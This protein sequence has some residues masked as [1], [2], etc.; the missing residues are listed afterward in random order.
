MAKTSFC[1][2]KIIFLVEEVFKLRSHRLSRF[3]RPLKNPLFLS[4]RAIPQFVPQTAG[5]QSI[6]LRRD[7]FVAYAPRNDI[8]AV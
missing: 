4:L 6:F 5:W 2:Y 3:M 7:C 8:L 1:C